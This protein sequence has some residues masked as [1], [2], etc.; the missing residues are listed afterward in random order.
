MNIVQRSLKVLE[1]RRDEILVSL[2]FYEICRSLCVL[3]DLQSV[4]VHALQKLWKVEQKSVVEQVGTE[5]WKVGI[6]QKGYERSG[7]H[8]VATLRFHDVLLD[9]ARKEAEMHGE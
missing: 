8:D 5:L 4:R 1:Q 3:L 7:E 6:A 9:I 2:S